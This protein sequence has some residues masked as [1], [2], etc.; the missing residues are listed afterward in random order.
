MKFDRVEGDR[1]FGMSG[2][3]G[4]GMQRTFSLRPTV[5]A[6]VEADGSTS[7]AS[8]PRHDVIGRLDAAQHEALRRLATRSLTVDELTQGRSRTEASSTLALLE[9]LNG[10][11]WLVTTV[12]ERGLALYSIEPHSRPPTPPDQSGPGTLSAFTLIRR[13]DGDTVAENPLSWCDVRVHDARVLGLLTGLQAGEPLPSSVRDAALVDLLWTGMMVTDA[14][15]DATP[16]RRRW[17]L[18]ELWFNQRS[19]MGRRGWGVEPFGATSW[20]SGVVAPLPAGRPT[21]P[22][23]HVELAVPDL[24]RLRAEDVSLTAAVEDRSSTRA[25]DDDRPLTLD[26]L[27]ELLFRTAR[28]RSVRVAG[29]VEVPSRPY[30]SGGSMYELEV[31][32]VVRHLD[33]LTAGMY[34]YD[35]VD[36]VLRPVADATHPAVERLLSAAS[37]SLTDRTAPQVLLVIAARPGRL[38]DTYEQ[39][40]Y[41]LILKHAGVLTQTISLVATAMGLGCVAVGAGDTTAFTEATGAD[42]LDECAVGDV[43]LGSILPAG[44]GTDAS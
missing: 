5:T 20:A 1:L 4:Q 30:P 40:G 31:Y 25:F 39:M 3:D 2:A 24:D 34:H 28:T 35:T 15:V 32:P 26:Q 12:R 6:S 29:A 11:G 9:R 36:H 27:A 44:T 13:R 21:Y 14:A 7:L 41:S 16:S 10:A 33:G 37:I 8:W 17:S 42:P 23:P 18:H 22:G 43:A 19:G 38:M